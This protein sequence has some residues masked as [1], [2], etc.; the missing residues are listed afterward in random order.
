MTIMQSIPSGW[1]ELNGLTIPSAIAAYPELYV[2]APASWKSGGDLSLPDMRGRMP[3]GHHAGNELFDQLEEKGGATSVTLQKA[4]VPKHKHEMLS[5][6]HTVASHGHSISEHRH[7]ADHEH[8]R[9]W[10]APPFVNPDNSN[11]PV[12]AAFGSG[13]LGFGSNT[14]GGSIKLNLLNSTD[15]LSEPYTSH[16]H[17]FDIRNLQV[18][19]SRV[20]LTTN[21]AGQQD[22]GSTDPGD[23]KDGTKDGLGANAFSTVSP[24]FV[25]RFIIKAH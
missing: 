5:H 12:V 7:T 22:T 13:N 17:S 14:I 20:G 19:T 18:N 23:T 11:V 16:S 21:N 10:T 2:A 9:V 4:N 8:G 6:T 24:Y 1:L 25:L 3:V 15:L